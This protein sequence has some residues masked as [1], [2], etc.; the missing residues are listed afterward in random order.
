MIGEK[1][2]KENT[3]KLNYKWII[4]RPTS[5]WG[6]W[7]GPTYRGFFEMILNKRY[8]NFS[9]KMSDKTYGYIGNTV[10]QIDC[11]LKDENNNGKTFYI[12]DYIPTNIKEW[13]IE[14]AREINSS[15]I[16]IPR[17][18]IWI[19]AKVGDVLKY[20]GFRFP[21]NSF[22]FSNMTTDNVL[23]LEETQK[24][25]PLTKYSRVEG[26]RTTIKWMNEFYLKK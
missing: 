7:F 14:I 26:N 10:Y 11:L 2:V 16:T 6:P 25:A 20:F 4:I 17:P 21:M 8:F 15:L 5:I 3:D 23:P 22:R 9:G 19:S 1:L 24:I 12:G 13:A 18:A